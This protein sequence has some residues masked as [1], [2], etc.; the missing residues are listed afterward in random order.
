ML[1]H[2]RIL[3]IEDNPHDAELIDRELRRAGL[4]FSAE[5]VDGE[6][7]LR[8]ALQSPPDVILADYHLP[9]FDG[10][11]ALRIAREVLPET[12]FLFVSGSIGE[13]RAV[14]ALREGATDY[15]LKDRL[16]RL[17][18]A[19]TRALEQQ[20]DRGM[21]RSAQERLDRMSEQYELIL[22]SSAEGIISVGRDGKALVVNPAA[23]KI[24]GYAAGEFLA[25]DS[26]HTLIHHSRPDGSPYPASEC[27]MFQTCRDGTSRAAEEIYW[28]KSG[29][30]VPIEFTCSAILDGTQIAGAVVFFQDITER[31]RLERRVQQAQRVASLGRVAATMAHEFNNVLMGIQPFGEVIRR[32]SAE[33]KSL[34]AASHILDSV[35][36]GRQVTQEILRFTRPA[37]LSLDRVDLHEWAVR[38]V[39]ELRG[40][41]GQRVAI[42]LDVPADPVVARCDAV[43]IQ[44]VMT[45][46]VLNARDAMP[47]GGSVTIRVGWAEDGS[48]M[49]LL[50]VQDTGSGIP[51]ESLQTI[52]EPLFTTKKSGTGLGLAV[53]HQVVHRHG[54]LIYAESTPGQGAL[55]TIHLPAAGDESPV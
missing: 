47:E 23:E 44:Q 3:M 11:E 33:P 50:S 39:P 30:A 34:N 36:R 7:T 24:T 31:Q 5:R 46:L 8:R 51:P 17:P 20:R 41:A 32:T 10:I 45:N 40:I 16:S 35:A 27:P 37:D 53:A 26:I 13:E 42:E 1:Q 2:I 15:I 52:F 19:I 54:G 49:A 9:A 14:Q 21:R 12:P 29:E 18:S 38:L 4:E 25:A 28:R 6:H 48:G 43:Q 22:Q 55:F